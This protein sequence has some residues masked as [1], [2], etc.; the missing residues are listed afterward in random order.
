MG[1][2]ILGGL[3]AVAAVCAIAGQIEKNSKT[4]IDENTVGAVGTVISVAAMALSFYG[5]MSW[6]GPKTEN[7]NHN[8][9][10]ARPAAES[11]YSPL[12]GQQ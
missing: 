1:A 7:R 2:G 12:L 3:T 11:N 6:L 9:N 4:R 8:T 10:P 5:V